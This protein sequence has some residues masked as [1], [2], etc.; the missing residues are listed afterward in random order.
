MKLYILYEK[1]DI[2]LPGKL[3]LAK[4]IINQSSSIKE[5]VLGYYRELLPEIFLSNN[6]EEIIVLFKD[7]YK[8]SESLI[9]ILNLKGI[10]YLAL[11]EEEHRLFN[12]L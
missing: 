4:Y 10:K 2:E 7:I 8:T 6:P 3:I 1:V 12:F 11:H 9:D 5:V